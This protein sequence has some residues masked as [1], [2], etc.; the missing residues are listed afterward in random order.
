L[1]A[2]TALVLLLW[3]VRQQTALFLTIFV[4]LP[5]WALWIW[6]NPLL[7]EGEEKPTGEAQP[8]TEER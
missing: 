6:F 3:F 4:L 2:L 7:E 1:A 5:L 8:P